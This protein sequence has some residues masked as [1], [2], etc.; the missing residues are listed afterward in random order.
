MTF[1]PTQSV[2]DGR[3]YFA[4]HQTVWLNLRFC[5]TFSWAWWS[6]ERNIFLLRDPLSDF[7]NSSL[8][9]LTQTC[10]YCSGIVNRRECSTCQSTSAAPVSNRSMTLAL[11]VS[12]FA[13]IS[14]QRVNLDLSYFH[15]NA[16]QWNCKQ[17]NLP[18][19]LC[20]GFSSLTLPSLWWQSRT[21]HIHLHRLDV[22]WP[23]ETSWA[24]T[25]AGWWS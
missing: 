16:A 7:C 19:D 2:W 21:E 5:T 20:V 11:A 22:K 25:A 13:V 18:A 23:S 3:A 10:W 17:T 24:I 6:A 12:L 15:S 8:R 4:H 9:S 1:A 14:R